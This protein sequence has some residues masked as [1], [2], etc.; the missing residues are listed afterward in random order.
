MSQILED[1]IS[2][3][4]VTDSRLVFNDGF[5]YKVISG[6]EEHT[7]RAFTPTSSSTNGLSFSCIPPSDIIAFSRECFI[8]LVC[9]IQLTAV[10]TA[11]GQRL[12][13]V[14]R[15]GLRQFPVS[16]IIDN[17]SITINGAKINVQ[18]AR[19]IHY[20]GKY[21][22]NDVEI[23]NTFLS[24]SPSAPDQSQEYADLLGSVR[25]PLSNMYQTPIN[26]YIGRQNGW[27]CARNDLSTAAG[28]QLTAIVN[29][30]V[31]E[32]IFLNPM[33]Y[34]HASSSFLH[35]NT[36]DVNL[37]FL[38][39]W[40]NRIWSSMGAAAG[41]TAVN[42]LPNSITGTINGVG[43]NSQCLFLTEF[44]TPPQTMRLPK[45][46]KY[47]YSEI[48]PYVSSWPS[49]PAHTST[50]IQSNQIQLAT[51]P[52][53]IYIVVKQN[54]NTLS[55]DCQQTDSFFSIEQ[56]RIQWNNKDSIFSSANNFQLYSMCTESGLNYNFREFAGEK[57]VS[58][59]RLD[60]PGPVSAE[61]GFY[62]LGSVIC[63][64]MGI[65]IPCSE[66][67][68]PGVV[69]NYSLSMQV[70]CTNLKNYAVQPELYITTQVDGIL[71]LAMAY[72][73]VKTAL[74]TPSNVFAAIDSQRQSPIGTH[75]VSGMQGGDVW[76]TVK[77]AF[78]SAN[79]F[80]RKH[81]IL[82]TGAQALREILP[83][84]PAVGP[85]AGT[86]TGVAARGLQ[87]L[88]YG[89]DYEQEGGVRTGGARMQRQHMSKMAK[90]VMY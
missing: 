63:L 31:F 81:K 29:I 62:P 35:V 39:T 48:N 50:V 68:S 25:N 4:T 64:R 38:A 34:K 45:V 54:F 18:L 15:C 36:F 72:A 9:S 21:F 73:N 13:D 89:E 57:V 28:Q 32:P 33:Q 88:G 85:L 24:G 79:D 41:N 44:I 86:L 59:F 77:N 75:E 56:L 19:Q 51:V 69:G 46:L 58:Q 65:D 42:I 87:R 74:L 61:Q 23:G 67:T 55:Q 22:H 60:G 80:L 5:A 37:T 78:S 83:Y 43:S 47:N 84:I 49:V 52:R 20:L 3:L 16:S 76:S 6:G 82:S 66:L 40:P 17:C 70:S 53:A 26:N 14:N 11:A 71:S 90:R 1:N 2:L 7:F 8:N 30:N 10:S 27:T 12:V